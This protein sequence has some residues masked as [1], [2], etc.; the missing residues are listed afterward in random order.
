MRKT[1]IR[2][3]EYHDSVFLLSISKK[4]R[5]LPGVNQVVAAMG[6]DMNKTV[7]E[8][9][10]L[11]DESG[12]AATSKDLILAL[13][14]AEEDVANTVLAE[15]DSCIAG[16]ESG[17]DGPKDYPSLD[18]ANAAHPDSNLVMISVPG[19]FA[20]LEAEHALEL[21]K[22]CFIFS[23][24]VE[25]VDEVALKK[26]G[27]EKG[28][29]VMGPGC[30]TSLIGGYALGM[31]SAAARGPIGIVG[32]SG[33]GIHQ[34]AM[35]IDRAGGGISHAIGTGGRDLSDEVGGST[36][37]AGLELLE[38]DP[39][40]KVLI[41]VS[42]PPAPAT[43]Q[44]IL[45]RVRQCSKPVIVHFLG[46]DPELVRKAGALAPETLEHAARMAM[47]LVAGETLP[48]S[49]YEDYARELD[50]V[51]ASLAKAGGGS[52]RGVF[53]GGTHAEEAALVL[54]RLGLTVHSNLPL[55]CC[56]SLKS[57]LQ[58]E[59]DCIIDIGDE[60]FTQ[61]K[62]HPVIEPS[63]INPRI[64][65]EASDPQ[66][67][68]ILLDILCGFGAH[69]DPAG[70]VGDSISQVLREAKQRGQEL[71]VVVSLCGVHNDPQDVEGQ[72][73]TLEEAGAVVFFNNAQAAYCAG[74]TI[75]LRR[76]EK[77]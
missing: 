59:G 71:A 66:T 76:G 6:T 28:L 18:M 56:A 7:L 37:L 5:A 62:P 10:G 19:A 34:M 39:E 15:L 1:I 23:D 21:G 51:A 67:G 69:P 57:P 13:D 30:G 74:K 65:Q 29:L 11:L 54:E 73:R 77:Q 26:L 46:G 17:G 58:S 31:M 55:P 33:S 3:G 44:R 16:G 61:G 8:D 27:R 35:I 24:N 70:V 4:L 63:I 60:I 32:A 52:L 38:Q 12:R 2:A 47:A 64:I 75:L 36:M 50:P 25:L 20:A 48:A 42:K 45:E 41:L 22:H 68:V 53:C 9:T 43:M 40:T 49:P 72:R 14:I